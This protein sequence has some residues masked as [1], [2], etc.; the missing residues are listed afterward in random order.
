MNRHASQNAGMAAFAGLILLVFGIW[1]LRHPMSPAFKR[2]E[3][4]EFLF[5]LFR[6]TLC[7][8]GVSLLGVAVICMIGKSIGL[9][10]DAIVSGLVGILLLVCA[11]GWICY[12]SSVDLT[13][14]VVLLVSLMLL[15]EGYANFNLWRVTAEAGL[16]PRAVVPRPEAPPVKIASGILPKEGEPP[17]PEGYLAALAKEKD[18]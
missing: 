10:L 7:I 3:F 2:G 14:I 17:P 6:W 5:V 4:Y 15:K 8:G 16:V 18:E 1:Y 13:N 12:E 9:L 11:V